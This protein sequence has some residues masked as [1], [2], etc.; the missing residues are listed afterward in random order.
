MSITSAKN[1]IMT[2]L[3]Y[4]HIMTLPDE[5]SG[6]NTWFSISCAEEENL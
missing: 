6:S 1:E 3:L 5:I 2:S 4:L